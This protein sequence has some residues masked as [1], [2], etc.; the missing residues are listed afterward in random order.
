MVK[1]WI[2]VHPSTSYYSCP[3]TVGTYRGGGDDSSPS[4]GGDD[5]VS[6]KG[7][8]TE[9]FNLP[10]SP[11]SFSPYSYTFSFP[12]IPDSH[13]GIRVIHMLLLLPRKAS[14]WPNH[15]LHSIVPL[16]CILQE[17]VSTTAHIVSPSLQATVYPEFTGIS[18]QVSLWSPAHLPS[19]TRGS[20]RKGQGWVSRVLYPPYPM[21]LEKVCWLKRTLDR[22]NLS[23]EMYLR[24]DGWPQQ[25][26]YKLE[27]SLEAARAPGG[28]LQIP[29]KIMS[30][31]ALFH[32]VSYWIMALQRCSPEW[33]GK[34]PGREDIRWSAP[35]QCFSTLSV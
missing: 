30:D 35:L 33:G 28:N 11:I 6:E 29:C 8:A 24:R 7:W 15:S 25:F 17:A 22:D 19:W 1:V 18:V 2:M 26:L 31:V 20:L 10:I 16:A 12:F 9:H 3:S 27:V 34:T 13:E 14:L 5:R 4:Q 21:C 23:W 32:H